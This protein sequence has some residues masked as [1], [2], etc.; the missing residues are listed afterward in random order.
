[1]AYF[2]YWTCAIALGLLT[3]HAA[4]AKSL[5]PNRID[6]LYAAPET[7]GLNRIRE[8]KRLPLRSASPP[9]AIKITIPRTDWSILQATAGCRR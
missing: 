5:R 4:D 6:I 8:L 3:P 7:A 9:E 2:S 1:M